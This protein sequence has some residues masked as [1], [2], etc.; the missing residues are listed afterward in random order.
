MGT[1]L[2]FAQAVDPTLVAALSSIA[3]QQAKGMQAVQQACNHLLNYVATHPHAFL[4]FIASDMIFA[5]H[6]NASYLSEP[7]S[8]SYATG[9][10]FLTHH[11]NPNTPHASIL[12]L[13]T[14]IQ[15]VLA[16]AS[17]TKLTTLFY[18]CKQD[19]P[20]QITLEK[21]GH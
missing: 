13:S 5:V 14:I 21:M 4:K 19:I 10:F 12:T 3:A 2:Y 20:L 7:N 18:G 11:N 1:L 6:A 17:Q 8:K 16:S 9:H 15:H